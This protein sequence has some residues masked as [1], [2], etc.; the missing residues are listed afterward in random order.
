VFLILQAK[1]LKAIDDF[2]K[3]IVPLFEE[4]EMGRTRIQEL[5]DEQQGSVSSLTAK[6]RQLEIMQKEIVDL[7]GSNDVLQR[8]FS[9]ALESA[10]LFQMKTEESQQRLVEARQ[11]LA[12]REEERRQAIDSL[13]RFKI[14]V[15][16]KNHHFVIEFLWLIVLSAH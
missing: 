8:Q 10:E 5:E 9:E 7:R 11:S 12:M 2:A 1:L 4:L 3:R 6:S 16:R 13:K 14:S 15:S